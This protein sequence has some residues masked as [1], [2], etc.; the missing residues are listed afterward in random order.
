MIK[1]IISAVLIVLS[2]FIYANLTKPLTAGYALNKGQNSALVHKNMN[3][4]RQIAILRGI[5]RV[6]IVLRKQKISTYMFTLLS[7]VNY[8]KSEGFSLKLKINKPVQV[9]IA[10]NKIPA[11]GK[12]AILKPIASYGF[13]GFKPYES[14]SKFAGVKKINIVL[15][16]K[17]YYGLVPML[18]VMEKLYMLF[19]IK[20]TN[21]T[22]NKKN[23]VI[24]FNL[25]SFKG[26]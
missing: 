17:G 2:V 22:I 16:F 23:T 14:G 11:P 7:F 10:A 12:K 1:I 19:P 20:Y 13:G 25:Y 24:N 5:K 6:K 26:V 15:N 9:K 18:S 21:F 4:K 3:Y 8:L